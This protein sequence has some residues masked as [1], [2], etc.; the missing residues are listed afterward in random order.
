MKRT[1]KMFIVG[2][3]LVLVA[4]IASVGLTQ[5]E[6]SGNASMCFVPSDRFER[7]M[8][9]LSCDAIADSLGYKA[10]SLQRCIEVGT[11][12][13]AECKGLDEVPHSCIL[14]GPPPALIGP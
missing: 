3:M 13:C 11:T 2:M 14:H 6:E 10:G 4:S 12:K 1:M 5:E 9:R 8:A 7:G